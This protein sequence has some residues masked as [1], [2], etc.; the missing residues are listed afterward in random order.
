MAAVLDHVFICTAI[1]APAAL[2]LQQFGLT[3][4]SPNRHPGQGTA[5]RRFFVRNAMLE[6]IWV[7]DA[8]ESQ[9]AET[10]RTRL[11][12]RWSAAGNR[13]SPFGIILRPEAD[14]QAMCPFL[15]WEYRPETMP[16][17]VLDIAEDTGLEE[18]MWCYMGSGRPP[19]PAPEKPIDHPGGFREITS[20]RVVCPPL[21]ET[22]LTKTM[23]GMN[24][25]AL[26]TGPKHLLIFEFDGGRQ[27]G[28]TD[29]RPDLPLVCRY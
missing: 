23:A 8:M 29:F 12:D 11:W 16:G 26:E 5:C 7:A 25:I 10:R 15:S 27:S 28:E 21:P 13:A 9:S 20:I 18:P 19:A 24:V 6:L 1:G 2:R 4:G 17:L 3:E 22:S 14:S